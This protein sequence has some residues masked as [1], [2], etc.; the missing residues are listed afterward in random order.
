M[1]K[2]SPTV[3]VT[4]TKTAAEA[5]EETQLHQE[6]EASGGGAE[7]GSTCGKGNINRVSRSFNWLI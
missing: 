2:H 3:Q 1:Q 6:V 5:A 7:H 4:E